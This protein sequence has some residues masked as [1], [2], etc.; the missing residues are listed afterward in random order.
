MVTASVRSSRCAQSQRSPAAMSVRSEDG[1]R[2]SGGGTDRIPAIRLAEI[3]NDTAFTPKGTAAATTN[4][5]APKGFAANWLTTVNVAY[6]RE[7]AVGRRSA[8]TV[9]GTNA[10]EAVSARVSPVPS[11]KNTT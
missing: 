3:R 6:S 8:G 7:L 9:A 5:H 4:S 1:S 11:V 10:A 2:G